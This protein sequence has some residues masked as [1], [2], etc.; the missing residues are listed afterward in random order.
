[1]FPHHSYNNFQTKYI[2][3]QNLHTASG[4]IKGSVEIVPVYKLLTIYT[5][6]LATREHTINVVIEPHK[7]ANVA[8]IPIEEKN[9]DQLVRMGAQLINCTHVYDDE[10][11][12]GIQAAFIC[13]KCMVEPKDVSELTHGA[14]NESQY[15]KLLRMFYDEYPEKYI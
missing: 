4:M 5:K 13:S 11:D 8:L 15:K 6:P 9:K 14:L 3:R 12:A 1:M 7:W 2:V 10:I